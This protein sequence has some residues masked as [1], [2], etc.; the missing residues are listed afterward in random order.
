MRSI[1]DRILPAV[2]AL[3]LMV[4]GFSSQC[5]FAGDTAVVAPPLEVADPFLLA[6]PKTAFGKDYL[7]SASLIPQGPSPTSH[8][9][10]GK[11]VRFEFFP[12]GVDLY[13]ST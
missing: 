9:L 13:E 3:G 2:A 5:A 7:F 10:A 12:D 4:F 11:V 6:I 1:V 8:G